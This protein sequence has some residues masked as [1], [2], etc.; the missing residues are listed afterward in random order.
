MRDKL[1]LPQQR[2][3]VYGLQNQR[4]VTTH[5]ESQASSA[6]GSTVFYT[7][8]GHY[9]LE[10]SGVSFYLEG[11]GT[12]TADWAQLEVNVGGT[13]MIAAAA[14]NPDPSMTSPDLVESK[15]ISILLLEGDA[16]TI[17]GSYSAGVSV[18]IL[19]AEIWGVLFPRANIQAQRV[20]SA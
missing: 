2:D 8:P 4:V 13:T 18:N 11:G 16:I 20:P 14:M 12:Q 6:F 5:T 17:R 3:V 1:Y 7:V 15:R 9:A 10:L 19:K